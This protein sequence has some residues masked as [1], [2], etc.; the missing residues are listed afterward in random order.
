MGLCAGGM[1]SGRIPRA[2]GDLEWAKGGVCDFKPQ[3]ALV[4]WCGHVHGERERQRTALLTAHLAHAAVATA[5]VGQGV[6][7]ALGPPWPFVS[8]H[9]FY[10]LIS[11]LHLCFIS[12]MLLHIAPSRSISLQM[13]S[14]DRLVADTGTRECPLLASSTLPRSPQ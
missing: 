12:R 9:L 6:D 11:T 1:S 2:D 7:S 5:I 3:L 4:R 10:L 14:K 8:T 13:D